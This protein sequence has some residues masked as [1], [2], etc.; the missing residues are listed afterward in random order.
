[1]RTPSAARATPAL[2]RCYCRPTR[3]ADVLDQPRPVAYGHRCAALHPRPSAMAAPR[4]I[5]PAQRRAAKRRVFLA[6][7]SLKYGQ[8]LSPTAA[9][10]Q[11]RSQS[12]QVV[13][14][15]E[16]RDGTR[17]ASA[18]AVAPVLVPATSAAPL[19]SCH[20]CQSP[21]VSVGHAA[22]PHPPAARPGSREVTAGRGARRYSGAASS[23]RSTAR[24]ACRALPA[25]LRAEER[26]CA[27]H[28]SQSSHCNGQRSPPKSVP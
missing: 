14:P 13:F 2:R 26:R 15:V 7:V 12:V 25:A 27:P 17:R 19:L 5:K 22:P 24:S 4:A 8:W 18:P 21:R 20:R 9:A 6:A 10:R 23:P 16:G 3:A 28:R 11:H 1:M